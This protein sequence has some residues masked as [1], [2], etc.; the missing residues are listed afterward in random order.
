MKV[1]EVSKLSKYYGNKKG[2]DNV[3]LE[4]NEG[5]IFGIIGPSGSG[6]TT[7]LRLLMGF[8]F[9]TNGKAKI[10]N[11]D[12]FKES[13]EI[14]RITSYLPTDQNFYDGNKAKDMIR[15]TASFYKTE[16]NK[17]MNELAT[18]LN[19]DLNRKIEDLSFGSRKKLAIICALIS[20]PKLLILDEPTTGLDPL[21]QT[22][23]FD[24]L[25]DANKNGTTIIFS[26]NNLIDIQNLCQ[27]VAIL[28]K[29]KI[30]EIKLIDE[31]RSSKIKKIKYELKDEVT[32]ST[33]DLDGVSHQL[34]KPKS[35]EFIYNGD[36]EELMHKLSSRK[37]EN[38][39]IE[40]PD[41]E[42]VFI[43]FYEKGGYE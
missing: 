8:L 3:D 1:V 11:H 9:P 37:I 20:Q 12:C 28:N 22:K 27:R 42:E 21:I 30:L 33:N 38:I 16:Y 36:I 10:F 24:V 26:T 13:K 17:R 23:L 31:L 32:I 40:D 39:W 25:R 35:V 43:H 19:L 18:I 6:K 34:I 29:G 2:I 14:K 7:L 15:Y 41:L 4:I 5:E